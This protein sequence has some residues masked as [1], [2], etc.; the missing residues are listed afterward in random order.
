[1]SW[2]AQ[3]IG[4][5]AVAFLANATVSGAGEPRPIPGTMKK[6]SFP[7]FKEFE[8]ENGMD[9]LVV[10]HHEQPV[11]SMYILFRVG[12]AHDPNGKEGLAGFTIDQLNKGTATR[13][14][15]ELA[16]WIES[17]G[18]RVGGSSSEDF[19][20][21]S[22][23]VLSEYL[24]VAYAYLQEVVLNPVFPEEEL[25]LL[26]KRVKTALELEKS[27]PAAVGQRYLRYAT[28]GDH[29]YHKQATAA[30]VEAI[31]REDLK[32]FYNTNFVPNNV[33]VAV[34]GDVKW[35]N[36]KKSLNN[37]FGDWQP[38]TPSKITYG[39]APENQG[40]S[41][42]LYHKTG[43]VQTEIFIGHLAPAATNPDWPAII[44]GNR[45]LGGGSSA[46]LFTNIRETK[47]WTYS[48]RSN[49][50]REKDLGQ[51][52]VR[53]P[54]RTEV[55]DSVLVE[56]M[57]E[58][59]RI[60]DEP[61][62]QEELDDAKSY[63]V[64]NFPLAIE[65]PGQI[66]TQVATYKLWG[67]D[68]ADLEGYR[69]R[70]GA[71]TVADVQQAMQTYLHPDRA[72]IV[73]VGDA[74]VIA[75]KVGVV[76]DVAMYDL[77]GEPFS[78]DLVEVEPV[79]YQYDTSK[80]VNRTTTYALTVQSM[81]IGEMNVTVEKTTDGGEEIIQVSSSVDGMIKLNE[82]MTFRAA[83]LSPLSY[84]AKIQM[85][86]QTMGSEFSFTESA[87]TGRLQSM[88]SPEP[89]E[90][91]FD[92]VGGTILDGA[93]EYAI[94]FLPMEAG[95]SYRFPIVDS[96]TGSVQNADVDIIEIIDV[97]TKAGKFSVFKVKI[98]RA[99]GEAYLYLDT[100]APHLLVK[101]EVPSQGMQLELTS[102]E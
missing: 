96:Q 64:G 12:D 47:G 73:L 30:T 50:S 85:G 92:L 99:D 79:D 25:D 22:I 72:Y 16:E 51:F 33:L 67:L 14:A 42:A 49:F 1:M 19:S 40:T 63:L 74:Q 66:A 94:T 54:V 93:I 89:T 31:T 4:F 18:G 84:S 95:K 23:T 46:R 39:G 76:A 21:I 36:V 8:L 69:E 62:T 97:E 100:M 45:V 38:G 37:H 26:Q 34:V 32:S 60:V 13:S 2:K 3:L 55:T 44:V 53:T 75:E 90:V 102:V 80:L 77:D 87:G 52:V 15:L 7:D 35:K 24:D 86:P 68:Q 70:I 29:P 11:V 65:T 56:L 41:I 10:E 43:A 17:V 9:V 82:N 101:Q 59:N 27:Q 71:V 5:V 98:K 81:A 6:L 57:S 20:A 61:V 78:L 28:Y 83:D 88:E 91:S 58:L 48:V